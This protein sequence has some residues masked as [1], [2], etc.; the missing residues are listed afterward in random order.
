MQR[1]ALRGD[2]TQS[3]R[4]DASRKALIGAT[5][6]VIAEEGYGAASLARISEAAGLS[7]GLANYHF[8]TKRKLIEAVIKQITDT[9]STTLPALDSGLT[10][11]EC[12]EALFTTYL[13][14]LQNKGREYSTSR[15]ML[16]LSAE[17]VT[18][19]PETEAAIRVAYEAVRKTIEEY[20][21]RGLEDGSIRPSVAPRQTA[22]LLHGLLRGIVL[23]HFLASD[24]SELLLVEHGVR[25]LLTILRT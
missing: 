14:G 17:A 13:R 12:I 20:L 4:T 8:G 5:F 21:D 24:D 11:Y 19:A 10:G 2:L 25:D 1:G 22:L 18:G 23:Q 15:V 9:Y 6:R 3:E 7:R 16:L